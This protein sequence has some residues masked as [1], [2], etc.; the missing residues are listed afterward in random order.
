MQKIY[1]NNR[2]ITLCNIEEIKDKIESKNTHPH[3][4]KKQ[5]SDVNFKRF[6]I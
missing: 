3:L 4:K 1:F 6:K 2:I 5:I